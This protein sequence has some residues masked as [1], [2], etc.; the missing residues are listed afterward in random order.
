MGGG[1]GDSI[2]PPA[3]THNSISF[4]PLPPLEPTGPDSCVEIVLDTLFRN[5]RNSFDSFSLALF[6]HVPIA[7]FASC[8]LCVYV[9]VMFRADGSEAMC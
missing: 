6:G 3:H 8:V 4:D 1:G 7:C 9:C 5:P 2:S